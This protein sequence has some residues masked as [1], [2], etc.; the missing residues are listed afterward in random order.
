[1][2]IEEIASVIEKASE[3]L[4][5]DEDSDSCHE[6]LETDRKSR[7]FIITVTGQLMDLALFETERLIYN[8]GEEEFGLEEDI[9]ED[10]EEDSEEKNPDRTV[11]FSKIDAAD[12]HLSAIRKL[13]EIKKYLEARNNGYLKGSLENSIK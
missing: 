6:C 10:S 11:F 3:E 5:K 8:I 1:M 12:K 13:A 4:A 9:E 2:N 7:E